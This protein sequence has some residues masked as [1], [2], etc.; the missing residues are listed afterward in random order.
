MA[1]DVPTMQPTITLRP[2]ATRLVPQGE[3]LGEAAGLIELDVDH[4]VAALERR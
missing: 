3:R 4:V 2:G 1:S